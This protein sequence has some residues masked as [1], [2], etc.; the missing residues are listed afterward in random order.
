MT[1]EVVK[2]LIQDLTGL[3][4][5]FSEYES[6]QTRLSVGSAGKNAVAKLTFTK[7]GD[8]TYL[9]DVYNEVPAKILSLGRG[10]LQSIS[11]VLAHSFNVRLLLPFSPLNVTSLCPKSISDHFKAETSPHL[12]PVSLST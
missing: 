5:A 2:D 4:S 1:Q 3:P 8:K 9:T 6:E 12:A 11:M 10:K 7:F